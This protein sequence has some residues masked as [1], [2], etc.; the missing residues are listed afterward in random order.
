[1]GRESVIAGAAIFALAFLGGGAFAA[2][3]FVITNSGQI[4]P[5]GSTAVA[6][7]GSTIA[8]ENGEIAL[9]GGP[10]L[11]PLPGGQLPVSRLE[12]VNPD[13]SGLR[14]VGPNRGVW[15]NGSFA[16]SRDG[17]QLAY[18]AGA[19]VTFGKFTLYL[20]GASG[21]HPRRLA[22][23]GDC[24]GVSWSPDGSQIAVGRYVAAELNVWVVNAKTGAMRRITDCQSKKLCGDALFVYAFQLQWSPNGQKIFFIRTRSDGGTSPL[25]TVRPDGSDLTEFRFPPGAH[26]GPAEWSPGGRELAVDS[27]IGVYVI[28]A[29]GA[30]NEITKLPDLWGSAW[31]PDGR[32]LAIAAP[33]GIYTVDADGKN[34]THLA[35]GRGGSLFAPTWSPDGT[36]LAYG[37]SLG[38][39]TREGIWT[40]NADGSDRRLIYRTI[41]LVASL[42]IVPAWSPDGRQLAFSS[43]AGTYVV[44]ADGRD[45]HRIARGGWPALAWQPIP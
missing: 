43:N 21:Q 30:V 40:I 28:D 32:E 9:A 31:S 38:P 10:A 6:P 33:R 17:K 7:T 45:V 26:P 3:R 36:E 5:N 12:F 29:D 14:D 23:C 19:S 11:P 8:A 15:G 34:L 13:G 1:M 41:P 2:N 39:G 37:G 22:A 42:A 18:L 27:A 35:A 24:E 16:W 4:K 20:V 25:G 44:N